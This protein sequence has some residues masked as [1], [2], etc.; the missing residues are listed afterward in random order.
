[1]KSSSWIKLSMSSTKTLSLP[2]W[3]LE[4]RTQNKR[5][6]SIRQENSSKLIS[7]FFKRV[8]LSWFRKN[9][10]II[11][12]QT[13]RGPDMLLSMRSI[14]RDKDKNCPIPSWPHLKNMINIMTWTKECQ[15]RKEIEQ[16]YSLSAQIQSQ[17]SMANRPQRRRTSWTRSSP[18]TSWVRYQCHQI[19]RS[20]KGRDKHRR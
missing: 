1:M 6:S 5:K 10:K 7:K 18:R 16:R 8:N 11:I 20:P 13:S 3:T 15:W 12:S 19:A 14:W 4:I 9:L 2:K 17:H